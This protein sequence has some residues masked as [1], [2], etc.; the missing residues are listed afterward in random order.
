MTLKELRVSAGKSRAEVASK[1][2]VCER[3]ISYY[4]NGERRLNVEQLLPLALLY[5]AT[6]DEIVEAAISI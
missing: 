5:G 1:L 3:T 4:E 2:N 6:L